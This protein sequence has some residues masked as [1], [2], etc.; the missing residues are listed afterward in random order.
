[1]SQSVSH[2]DD[3]EVESFC[4]LERSSPEEIADACRVA[5]LAFVSGVARGWTKRDLAEWL[6]GPYSEAACSLPGATEPAPAVTS[7]V[8]TVMLQRLLR[9]TR[10]TV[11]E[12]LSAPPDR[13]VLLGAWA[14][15]AG[16]IMRSQHEGGRTGWIPVSLPRMRL[17]DRVLSLF[18][19]DVLV[20]RHDYM[21]E[22]SI[23]RRCRSVAFDPRS[24]EVG[25]CAFH[26]TPV[27][28]ASGTRPR[29]TFP[30]SARAELGGT[31]KR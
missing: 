19:V 23:C 18:A 5:G 31:L 16:A 6:L 28:S 11:L 15:E 1:M 4:A 9:E 13:V 2:E 8:P 21:T 24:R 30:P 22:L 20:R 26:D 10:A 12:L 14:S 7:P 29:I 17:E 3:V 25:L 27:G